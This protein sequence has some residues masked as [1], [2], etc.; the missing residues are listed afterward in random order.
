MISGQA[1][2]ELLTDRC[3]I[4]AGI[5]DEDRG[6][7]TDPGR[8]TGAPLTALPALTPTDS[9]KAQAEGL[10][11]TPSPMLRQRRDGL[12]VLDRDERRGRS[13]PPRLMRLS[14]E[15]DLMEENRILRAQ[16]GGTREQLLAG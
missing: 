5:R 12:T 2:G 10:K 1:K 9:A 6:S 7:H 16:L 4:G 8:G 14:E 15:L 3:A 11:V 13:R